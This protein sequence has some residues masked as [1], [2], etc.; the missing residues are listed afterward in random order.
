MADFRIPHLAFREPH[1][2]AVGPEERVRP[3]GFEVGEEGRADRRDHV[4]AGAVAAAPAVEDHEED[5]LN[6]FRHVVVRGAG[7]WAAPGKKNAVA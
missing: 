3:G 6:G 2:K 4:G 5:F 7:R 1:V